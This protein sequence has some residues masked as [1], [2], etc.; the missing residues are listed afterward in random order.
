MTQRQVFQLDD[1]KVQ[2]LREFLSHPVI[3]EAMVIVKQECVPTQPLA[4]PG[5]D[6]CHLMAIEGAKAVGANQFF[7]KLS[8][9][10]ARPIIADKPEHN[11]QHEAAIAQLLAT[12]LYKDRTEIERLLKEQP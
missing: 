2:F 3:V 6:M 1:S 5:V 4:I 7:Q 9:L 10:S 11:P 8:S 12:G